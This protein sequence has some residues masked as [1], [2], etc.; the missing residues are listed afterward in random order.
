METRALSQNF[1]C[2]LFALFFSNTKFFALKRDFPA[3]YTERT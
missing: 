2:K 1:G 3:S